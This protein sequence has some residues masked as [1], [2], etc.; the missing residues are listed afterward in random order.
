MPEHRL[1]DT[2]VP[3]VGEEVSKKSSKNPLRKAYVGHMVQDGI[4][5]SAGRPTGKKSHPNRAHQIIGEGIA[6]QRWIALGRGRGYPRPSWRWRPLWW[7]GPSLCCLLATGTPSTSHA[8]RYQERTTRSSAHA[9]SAIAERRHRGVLGWL[10]FEE[11]TDEA[12][13]SVTDCN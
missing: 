7:P 10:S 8:R 13:S 2:S 3:G 12:T 9:G 11:L 1:V 4:Q 6:D 5:L